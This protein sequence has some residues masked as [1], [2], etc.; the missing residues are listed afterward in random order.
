M[1]VNEEKQVLRV[2]LRLLDLLKSFF[3]QEPDAERM[4]RWRG[5]FTALAENKIQPELDKGARQLQHLLASKSLEDIKEEYYALFVDPYNEQPVELN[6]SHYLDGKSFGPSLVQYR[7]LFK[8]ASLVKENDVTEPEDHLV[9]MLD[10]LATLIE[11]DAETE[12]TQE[13]QAELITMFLQP[14]AQAMK[15][16]LASNTQADFYLSCAVFLNGYL[17]LEQGLM[18][19]KL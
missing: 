11:K 17:D 9:L 4:S 16:Q 12:G 19:I 14:M 8:D 2:R 15:K 1:S 18:E 3:A 6:A 13:Q 5:I 10:A 7:Q